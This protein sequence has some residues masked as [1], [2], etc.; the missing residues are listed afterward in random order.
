MFRALLLLTLLFGLLPA[1]AH[2]QP[3]V[4]AEQPL[5]EGW[6][7]R[8]DRKDQGLKAGW[9][10]GDRAIAWNRVEVPHVFDPTPSD[11][12]FGGTI[13]W[14]RL[15]FTGPATPPGFAW[16]LRFEGAR[17]V[18]RVWLNGVELGSNGN[19]Y[20][21]FTL[22]ARGLKP[23]EPNELVV[24]VHNVRPAD[25][26]EGWWNWGGIVRPVTLIPRGRIAYED[27][28]VLSD[29]ECR[30]TCSAIVRTDGWMVNRTR[31]VTSPQVTFWMTSPA[32]ESFGKTVTVRN[33]R[34]GERRRVSF[35]MRV[36]GAP[37]L[38]SP[39]AP[40]LYGAYVETRLGP[41]IEQIDQRRV[42]LRYIRVQNGALY[43]N[44]HR[45]Q[46]R[47]AAIQE[48]MPGRGPAL[49]EEDVERVVQDLKSLGAN[50]T[51]AHYP[52]SERLLERFD[53]EGIMV[54]SQAP[55]YHEDRQLRTPAGRR[56][57]YRKVRGTVITDRN[58]P[59]VMTHSVANEL[60][61]EP[62]RTPGTAAFLRQA[63]E[64]TRDLDDTV[65]VSVDLLSYPGIPRQEAYAAFGLL[66]VNSYYG[67]YKGKPGRRSTAQL[68]DLA[69]YLARMRLKYPEQAMMITEFGA[70]AT[71]AG[72]A[73]VKETFA[74][75][76]RYVLR[77]LN[78]VDR[79]DWLSGAIYWTAREFYV[80]PQ[81]DGGANRIG[82]ERD[83]LHNKGLLTYEGQPKP[84]FLAT[85]ERFL[86]TPVYD[87]EPRTPENDP[88]EPRRRRTALEQPGGG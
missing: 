36:Q 50:V 64:I 56:N 41:E 83:A 40:N 35:P 60:V 11:R 24:R 38:W 62:D 10:R 28:G 8:F 51:R 43:L 58:H 34:P 77:T 59:S 45:L 55:V 5:E 46:M 20:Q 88:A 47:G 42:G 33:L 2:A 48:D 73:R 44:G 18:A 37:A 69:P 81:W 31:Q 79:L 49:H 16:A 25:L 82:V 9:A 80:K 61:I 3:R 29:V 30:P 22:A 63:A 65:P 19:P 17:R 67:W 13:G 76:E 70:E 74:F 21:A 72:P 57:A 32:G 4:P 26:R 75:Q 7:F 52:L 85:R 68:S 84:A 12:E 39:R 14:Y 27:L 53:E 66:G 78:V 54:W 71:F 6:E 87:D 23:G 86:K 1:T 15:R